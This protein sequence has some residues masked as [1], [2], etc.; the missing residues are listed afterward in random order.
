[1]KRDDEEQIDFPK[2]V[3]HRA[4]RRDDDTPGIAVPRLQYRQP[5]VQM[6]VVS[7]CDNFI[8]ANKEDQPRSNLL[9]DA[10]RVTDRGLHD[11]ADRRNLQAKQSGYHIADN[12]QHLHPE[13][14][15]SEQSKEDG[16]D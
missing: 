13:R 1:M 16:D 5:E 3:M 2:D 15:M 11:L 14:S 10:V 8:V 7:A 12:Q 6:L 9:T 4:D